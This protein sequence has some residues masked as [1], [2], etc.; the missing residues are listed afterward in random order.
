[1]REYSGL[2]WR[3]IWFLFRPK[4]WQFY[5]W[6]YERL[7]SIERVGPHGE[8]FLRVGRTHYRG[9]ELKLAGGV[10]LR[11]GQIVGEI[12]LDNEAVA[13]F[14]SKFSTSVEFYGEFFLRFRQ[15][16]RFLAEKAERDPRF[17]QVAAFRG[18]TLLHRGLERLGF[19][20]F[21]LERKL[22]ERW[23]ARV[24]YFFLRHYSEEEWRKKR[25][26]G[27]LPRRI[28]ISHPR[29]MELYREEGSVKR[30]V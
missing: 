23:Q 28:W 21:P 5:E 1:M 27:E 7:F 9:P 10:V 2:S 6:F 30:D 16:M 8:S 14:R 15:S 24:Q 12:H 4:F 13:A 18:T 11:T 29:L 19:E 20:T 26:R 3:K 17:Q 25:E 22:N